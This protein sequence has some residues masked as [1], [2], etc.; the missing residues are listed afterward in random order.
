[1]K[2]TDW[3]KT[4]DG[5][6]YIQD[7]ADFMTMLQKDLPADNNTNACATHD[8]YNLDGADQTEVLPDSFHVNDRACQR[9]SVLSWLFDCRDA[10]ACRYVWEDDVLEYFGTCKVSEESSEFDLFQHQE[11]L[12]E[13]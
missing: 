2:T 12:P 4:A 13:P 10:G 5:M 1:M 11:K 6:W 3:Q 9:F 8:T 7:Y